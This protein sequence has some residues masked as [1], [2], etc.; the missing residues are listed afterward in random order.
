MEPV[1]V[2]NI[3]LSMRTRTRGMVIL[4]ERCMDGIEVNVDSLLDQPVALAT[5][6]ASLA[7]HSKASNLSKKTVLEKRNF[8]DVLEEENVLTEAQSKQIF[9]DAAE[10]ANVSNSACGRAEGKMAVFTEISDE[11]RNSVAAETAQQAECR[12]A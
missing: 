8:R 5:P 1:I 11:D 9:R 4:K 7:G 2:L 6:L 12:P 10:F 3:L